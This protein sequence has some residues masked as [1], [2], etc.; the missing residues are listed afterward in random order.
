[1]ALNVSEERELADLEG[2]V[3]TTQEEKD[4]LAEL[5]DRRARVAAPPEAVE[6][7]QARIVPPGH[8]AVPARPHSQGGS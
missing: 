1:M 8:V 6:S 4:R 5:I 3:L 7:A 2:R